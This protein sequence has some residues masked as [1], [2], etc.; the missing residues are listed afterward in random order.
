MRIALLTYRGNMFCGGQG[1][2]AAYLARGLK[3]GA[4]TCAR[5]VARCANGRSLASSTAAAWLSLSDAFH[6]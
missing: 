2:Y 4:A 1:I 3:M 6:T 5:R